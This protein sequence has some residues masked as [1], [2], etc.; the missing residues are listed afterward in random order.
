MKNPSPIDQGLAF[1]T[2]A[3]QMILLGPF[4]VRTRHCYGPPRIVTL[5]LAPSVGKACVLA[6]VVGRNSFFVISNRRLYSSSIKS[7]WGLRFLTRGL[8]KELTP[9]KL[10]LLVGSKLGAW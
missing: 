8:A 4:Y 9:L 7:Y 5:Q 3:L 2:H 10:K 1:Q 6:Q